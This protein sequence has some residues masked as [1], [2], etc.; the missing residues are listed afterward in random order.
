MRAVR[1]T[2]VTLAGVIVAALVVVVAADRLE[3]PPPPDPAPLIAKARQYDVRIKRD[4]YGVPHVFGSRDADVAFGL[5]F[6]HSEDDFDTLQKV[7]LATRG[8]LAATEGRK[9]AVAD[10]LVHLLRVWETVEAKY[11]SDLPPD[12]AALVADLL[13][14]KATTRELGT[15]P[16]PQ[17]LAVFIDE[18]LEWARARTARRGPSQRREQHAMCEAFFAETVR[19]FDLLS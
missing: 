6:A 14:C 17:Q 19:R 4:T 13:A 8:R 2:L 18:E 1:I 7:A 10:Y 5:A 3:Q 12:V 11:E 9:A 15:G 16:L